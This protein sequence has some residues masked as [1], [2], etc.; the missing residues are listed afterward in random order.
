[1]SSQSTQSS[2]QSSKSWSH[3]TG[4][5]QPSLFQSILTGSVAGAAEVFIDHPLFTL[6]NFIQTGLKDVSTGTLRKPSF[7]EV[8]H[9]FSKDP[10]RLYQG[11]GANAASMIPITAL[12]VGLNH[13]LKTLLLNNPEEKLSLSIQFLLAFSAGAAAALVASPVER[14]ITMKSNDQ[15]Q[16]QFSFFGAGKNILKQGGLSSLYAGLPMTMAR[17]GTFTAFYLAVMPFLKNK[18]DP[19][20]PYGLASSI[21]AGVGAGLAA[22]PVSQPFD[23]IKTGQQQNL[24]PL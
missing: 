17:D 19:E 4:K 23:V 22:T 18:I 5:K 2:G 15:F 14:V 12:Q 6:K 16:S 21:V 11:V 7:S 3:S 1:M 10:K 9:R 24:I 13:W 20:D 8:F